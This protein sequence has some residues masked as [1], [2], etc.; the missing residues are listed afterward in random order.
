MAGPRGKFAMV[1]PE[2]DETLFEALKKE[3]SGRE[4]HAT[5]VER[6]DILRGTD[7]DGNP[8][9]FVRLTLTEPPAG[10]ETWPSDDVLRLRRLVRD[11]LLRMLHDDALRWYVSFDSAAAEITTDAD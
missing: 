11:A 3:L 2:L 5:R 4:V 7:A 10:E 1:T 6:V 9:L 8:A